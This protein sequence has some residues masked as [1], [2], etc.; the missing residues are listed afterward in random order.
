MENKMTKL[1]IIRGLANFHEFCDDDLSNRRKLANLKAEY[2][3]AVNKEHWFDITYGGNE[4]YFAN[5]VLTIYSIGKDLRKIFT[6]KM[7]DHLHKA[8]ISYTKYSNY[9]IYKKTLKELGW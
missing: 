3:I 1:K 6:K 8:L 9:P 7:L 4:K 5:I 2:P